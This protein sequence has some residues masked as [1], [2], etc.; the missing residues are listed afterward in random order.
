[1]KVPECRRPLRIGH[2]LTRE[3]YKKGAGDRRRE[4]KKERKKSNFLFATKV[5]Y[6]MYQFSNLRLIIDR[7][8][9]LPIP[10]MPTYINTNSSVLLI[11]VCM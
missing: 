3:R 5:I 8:P 4:R 2:Q 6:P 7:Q 11:I 9:Y 1:M 10:T